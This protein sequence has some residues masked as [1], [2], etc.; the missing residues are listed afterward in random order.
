MPSK[1]LFAASFTPFM[2]GVLVKV[3]KGL[4]ELTFLAPNR[5]VGLERIMEIIHG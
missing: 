3:Q 2:D 5:E 4:Q 1:V